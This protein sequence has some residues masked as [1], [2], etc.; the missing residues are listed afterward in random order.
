MQ[1][2]VKD[3]QQHIQRVPCQDNQAK[4]M[5]IKQSLEGRRPMPVDLQHTVIRQIRPVEISRRVD[6]HFPRLKNVGQKM[7]HPGIAGTR[8][9]DDGNS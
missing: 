2:I 4:A 8:R 7:T 6:R 9:A 3:R 5:L 1:G